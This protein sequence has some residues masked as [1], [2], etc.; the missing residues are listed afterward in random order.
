MRD[1]DA[2]K[3]K[4]VHVISGDLWAGAEAMACN[5]LSCLN[6]YPD[7][8]LSVVLLNEG[9]LADGLREQGVTVHVIDERRHSFGEIVRA[10]R[11]LLRASPPDVIHSHRYKENILTL[12][13]AGPGSRIRLVA[14]QHGLP[15][16]IGKKSPLAA[17]FISRVNFHILSRYFTKTVAVS[18][19]VRKFLVREHG[20]RPENVEVI[21]NGIALPDAVPPRDLTG[22]F[23]IGSSGRLYRVKDYPLMIEIARTTAFLAGDDDIRFALA[24]EGPERLLLEGL[25][26]RHGLQDRFTLTGHLDDMNTFYRGLH[27]YLNTSVHEGIPL[28]ILEALARGLPVIAPAVGGIGEII[29]DGV[30]GFL[31]EGRTPTDFAEKCLLVRKNGELREKMSK[32]ARARVEHAFSVKKMAENYYRLCYRPASPLPARRLDNAAATGHAT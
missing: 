32:A 7:L 25:I 8:A 21:H 24:G 3:L 28:T 20:F 13:A 31:I 2:T 26:Q 18:E 17:R 15:E 14:T 6:G 5:L 11:A 4:V 23:V 1:F 22:P 10:S 16:F 9:R 30:E 12:L 19:S 29:E 27:L